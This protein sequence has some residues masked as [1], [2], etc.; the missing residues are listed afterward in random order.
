MT[1]KEENTS[2]KNIGYFIKTLREQKGLTQKEFALKLKTSQSA[3][4]RMENGE[5]NF[6][7][8]QL[9]KISEVL[10]HK[11]VSIDKSQDFE[12]TGGA[13]LSGTISTNTS[14]N[15]ALGLFC[16]S[17]L[18]KSKTILH[19]I[20]RIEEIY[21]LIEIFE[22]IG[23]HVKWINTNTVEIIP[24]PKISLKNMNSLAAGR[25]RSILML[26]GALIHLEKS[27]SIPHAG[28]CKMGNRTIAAHRYGL[29]KFGVKIIT[30]ADSYEI[31][32]KKLHSADIT[33]YEASDTGAINLLIAAALI[34]ETTIIDFAPPNYQLQEVC[35]FLQ[36]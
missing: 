29:E 26:I 10:R 32:S 33:M 11:I 34:P 1:Q 27:F 20:P 15:G 25:I 35:F 5:Q 2:Q 36:K 31:S 24:P 3:V 17:L 6:S 23:I 30:K 22:S 13:K 28:G 14:K 9:I 18:N 21:R 7:T 19:G 4:A 8:G 16:A 12:I